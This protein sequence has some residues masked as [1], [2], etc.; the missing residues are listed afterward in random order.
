MGKTSNLSKR[1]CAANWEITHRSSRSANPT[2]LSDAQVDER[3]QLVTQLE[4]QQATARQI[5]MGTVVVN[6]RTTEEA[7]RS[8]RDVNDHVD[9][10]TKAGN[11]FFQRGWMIRVKHRPN[12]SESSSERASEARGQGGAVK[13]SGG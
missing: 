1:L 11:D 8:I 6:H 12:G 7:N 5:R 10:A 13:G 9:T 3:M 4:L 2:P